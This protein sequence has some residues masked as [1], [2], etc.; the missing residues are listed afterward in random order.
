MTDD[1]TLLREYA[2]HRSET[3]FAELVSRHDGLVYSVALRQTGN[4]ALAEEI[5]QV[6]FIILARKAASL[7]P[8]TILPGWLCRTARYAAANAL[9]IQRRR[10]QREQEAHMQSNLNE[11]AHDPWPEIAPLLDAALAQLG[12]RDHDALVLRYFKNKTFQEIGSS[13]GATENSARKRVHYGL[14]KLRRYFSKRGVSSTTEIIA[15][16]ISANA[17]LA[18]PAGLAKTATALALAKAPA[19]SGSTL[20]LIKGAFKIMAW[21]KA[22][23]AI[24]AGAAVLLAAGSTPVLIRKIQRHTGSGSA[25]RTTAATA[26]IHGQLFGLPQLVDAGNATPEAAW[27]TRYWARARGD[28]DAVIA[29]TDPQAVNGAKDWMGDK[30]TFRARSQQEFAWLQGFQILARKNLDVDK[31]ELKY[32]FAFGTN[33]ASPETKIVV[34]VRVNG[35][36]KCAQTRVYD[37]GW[38]DGSEPEPQS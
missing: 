12:E 14:E 30:Y 35:V 31:V 16:A 11:P 6:T 13:F 4:P 36:W 7:G 25:P 21:T 33:P 2:R 24:I 37:A 10:Q 28:Y 32:Q 34:M 3:A 19:A 8:K 5:T 22:K 26:G 17:V 18:A 38:D 9:T 20:S 15:G 29:A 1:L 23:T 27:E